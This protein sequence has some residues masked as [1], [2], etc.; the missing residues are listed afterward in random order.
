MP[1]NLLPL[2]AGDV[3]DPGDVGGPDA[4][5]SLRAS[6]EQ[7]I[8]YFLQSDFVQDLDHAQLLEL[9]SMCCTWPPFSTPVLRELLE[10]TRVR[11]KEYSRS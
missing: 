5:V 4:Y 2:G 10:T 1:A 3:E 9:V 11:L 8:G 7:G 6:L